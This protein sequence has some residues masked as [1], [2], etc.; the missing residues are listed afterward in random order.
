MVS[1]RSFLIF[2]SFFIISFYLTGCIPKSEEIDVPWEYT[3]LRGF[4]PAD[5][6]RNTQDIIAVYSRIRGEKLQ[7][8]LDLLDHSIL[9]EYDLYIAIDSKPGG[10]KELP[11][12]A[13][14]D[15]D[16]DTLVIVPSSGNFQVLDSKL[17]PQLGSA[18]YI[19]RDSFLDTIILSLNHHALISPL[20]VLPKNPRLLFQTFSTSAGSSTLSDQTDPISTTSLPPSR[21]KALFAF[22]N[23]YPSYTPATAL[24]RWSGAHTGPMGGSHGL[25]NLLMAAKS[26]NI[27]LVLLDLRFLSSLS[28]LDFM[29]KLDVIKD[30]EK[31]GLLILPEYLPDL[32]IDWETT[33][34]SHLDSI[35]NYS[36]RISQNMGFSP[37][38]YVS[39]PAGLYIYTDKANIY[40]SRVFLEEELPIRL[41]PTYPSRLLDKTIIPVLMNHHEQQASLEGPTL[42]VK[43]ALLETALY[44]PNNYSSAENPIL[45]LGGDLPASTWGISPMA[46]AT[47]YYLQKHPWVQILTNHEILSLGQGLEKEDTYPND[48]KNERQNINLSYSPY[49]PSISLETNHALLT[50]LE[51]CQT[52]DR[53]EEESQTTICDAAWQAYL[54]LFSPIYPVAQNLPALRTNYIGQ[55]WSLIEAS[56]WAESPAYQSTCEADPDRDGQSECILSTTDVYIQFEIESGSIT[57]TL[58]KNASSS[59]SSYTHQVI[60]P[61]SQFITGLSDPNSW[62]LSNGLSSDPAVITGG[63]IENGF[64]YQAELEGQRIIFTSLDGQIH[65]TFQLTS[66]GVLADYKISAQIPSLTTHIS[67]AHDP[68]K[69]FLPGWKEQYNHVTFP[70]GLEW[71]LKENLLVRIQTSASLSSSD[72]LDSLQFLSKMENPNLDYPFGHFLPFPITLIQIQAN[73]DF[74]VTINFIAQ[75][76][77]K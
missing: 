29:D 69:R 20:M 62:N 13:T 67:I 72:F 48:I 39:A 23:T 37:N 40:F 1:S 26:A 77:D 58:F 75:I 70:N 45:V 10:S 55:I 25:S 57:Y 8:R 24:R 65:K 7:I 6:L 19:Q 32:I 35:L 54:A 66:S 36:R 52:G 33:T 50:E 28:G 22:W 15:L 56:K 14:S 53:F 9:P 73:E 18:L 60:A 68:W 71:Q 5:S 2:C 42:E 38:A 76:D 64:K 47:F 27:P 63:F 74:T 4:D 61:S 21:A 46:L 41:Q 34:D 51:K 11:I 3:D 49:Q 12:Q 16:W 30:M 44:G 31:L 43:Q 59:D 17:N